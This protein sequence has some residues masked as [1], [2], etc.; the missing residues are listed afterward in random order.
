MTAPM[1]SL[2][3]RL[4]SKGFCKPGTSLY[5]PLSITSFISWPIKDMILRFR[6]IL[7]GILNFYSFADNIGSLSYIYYL[8][9]GSLRNTICR[10]LDIGLRTFYAIF[11]PNITISVYQSA[12]RQL[13]KLDFPPFPSTTPME[14][15]RDREQRSLSHQRLNGVYYLCPWSMLCQLCLNSQYPNASRSSH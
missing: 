3:K 4:K 10:K 9:H 15:Q 14:L 1:D 11:G 12:T 7:A 8:L 2:L 5:R 6:T 13:V